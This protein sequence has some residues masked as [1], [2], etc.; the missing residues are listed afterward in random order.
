MTER[1]RIGIDP[2]VVRADGRF[3]FGGGGVP[4]LQ[5]MPEFDVSFMPDHGPKL[6]PE[7]VDGFDAIILLG[8]RVD[9][10]TLAGN[11]RLALV[12]RCGVGYDNV[13]VPACTERGVLVTITPEALS[14]PMAVVNLTYLLALSTRL[15]EQDRLTRA[16]RWAEKESVR[17]TGLMGKTVGTVGFGRI[18]QEF[19]TISKPLGMRHLASDPYADT[20]AAETLGVELADLD[21]LLRESDFVVIASAL[22]PETRHLIDAERLALMKP[23]AYLIST[24]RGPIVD[25]TALYEA[26]RERRIAGAGLD[27]FEQEPVDPDNPIL[28]LDNVIVSPHALCWTDECDRIMGESIVR[29]MQSVAA[30]QAPV[31]AV[32]RDAGDSPQVQ[33]RL[34]KIVERTGTGAP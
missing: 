30:G 32:N 13:D 8:A 22:T 27:V 12:A 6:G 29:A 28:A 7:H 15:L 31:T 5:Q 23:A 14:R 16:G 10:E 9:G 18:A 3:G 11:D 34:Q 33:S 1:F 17:G 19:H 26:L 2:A 25:E 20:A 4:M 24:A 21:Q